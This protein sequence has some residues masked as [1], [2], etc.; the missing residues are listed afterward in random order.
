M[1]EERAYKAT[2]LTL[3][4]LKDGANFIDDYTIDDYTIDDYTGDV[5]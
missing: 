4:G 5:P 2:W 3:Q 1:T